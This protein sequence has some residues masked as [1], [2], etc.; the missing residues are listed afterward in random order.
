METERLTIKRVNEQMDVVLNQLLENHQGLI[1]TGL[2]VF[3]PLNLM[4]LK[5][6]VNSETILMIQ[7]KENKELLGIIALLREYD[8][9]GNIIPHVWEIGYFLLPE[10]RHHGYMTEGV[11]AV[12]SVLKKKNRYAQIHALVSK[13]NRSSQRVLERCQ[14]KMVEMNDAETEIWKR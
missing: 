5:L 10:K 1:A 13:N 14:F 9:P 7:G 6:L 11:L 4:T 2:K 3:G 12:C 8:S